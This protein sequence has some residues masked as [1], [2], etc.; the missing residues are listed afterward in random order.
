MSFAFNA[1]INGSIT[2]QLLIAK[3]FSKSGIAVLSLLFPAVFSCPSTTPLAVLKAL[4]I[5]IAD[6][7][8]AALKLRRKVFP[9]MA[10]TSPFVGFVKA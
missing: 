1:G 5:W 3:L 6:F 2:M 8:S 7:S 9:S 4:I 10:I